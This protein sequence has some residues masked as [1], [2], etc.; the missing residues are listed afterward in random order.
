[1]DLEYNFDVEPPTAIRQPGS[2]RFDPLLTALTTK[3]GQWC[4]ITIP[5]LTRSCKAQTPDYVMAGL[6]AA[7]GANKPETAAEFDP[8]TGTESGVCEPVEDQR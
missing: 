7:V 8:G 1:M 5:P 2:C 4:R 3:P 6:A